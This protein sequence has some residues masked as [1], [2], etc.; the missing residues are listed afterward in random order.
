MARSMNGTVEGSRPLSQIAY[1][2]LRT[3]ILS[4][5]VKPGERLSERDLARRVQVSRTPLREALGRLERDGLAVSKPGLGY[6]ATEFDP[7]LVEELYE[8]REILEVQASRLAARRISETGARDL[9]DIMR[10][11]ARFARKKKLSMDELREEV[12]LGL[13][14]H[15][16]IARESGNALIADALYQIY[17]RVRLLT[18]I[19]VLWYDTWSTTRREHRDLVAAVLAHDADRAAK[20]AQRHVRRSRN[21]SVHVLK[22]QHAGGAGRTIRT[23]PIALS[24][25]R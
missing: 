13:R 18:W 6:F 12:N 20:V 9:R 2:A 10:Q 15:E 22:A 8:F 17:D 19:D 24:I 11:L 4:G 25:P 16:V 3:M 5:E 7:A 21:G 14:I 23:R 1:D